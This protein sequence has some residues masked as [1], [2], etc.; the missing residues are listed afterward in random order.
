[1]ALHPMKKKVVFLSGFAVT[2]L[3][4]GL[5]AYKTWDPL[6]KIMELAIE[7][8]SSNILGAEVQIDKVQLNL[9][10]GQTSFNYFLSRVIRHK[11]KINPDGT[12]FNGA[13][14]LVQL[15]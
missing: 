1:M 7:N 3:I 2:I 13:P 6:D 11:I 14:I 9:A 8:Y 12:I 15:Q 4:L 5:I 10:E